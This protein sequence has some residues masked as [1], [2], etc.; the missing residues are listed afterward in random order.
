MTAMETTNRNFRVGI[1]WAGFQIGTVDHGHPMVPGA[2][3]PVRRLG[4]MAGT[5]RI[6]GD[7]VGPIGDESD[8]APLRNE[9]K[10][11]DEPLV[12]L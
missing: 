8:W 10:L 12:F 7:I 9:M 5:G 1:H 11:I 6:I 4:T 2:L 3:K